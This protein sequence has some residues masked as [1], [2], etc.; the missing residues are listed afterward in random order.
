MGH[1]VVVVL[2]AF[3]FLAGQG[4]RQRGG[5]PMVVSPMSSSSGNAGL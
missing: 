1:V 4:I 2:M 5:A 3:W